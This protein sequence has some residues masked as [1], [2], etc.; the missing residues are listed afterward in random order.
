MGNVLAFCEFQGD[1]LRTSALANI[2]SAFI[3]FLGV[4]A[5]LNQVGVAT[6]VTTP[7]LIAQAGED[8]VVDAEAARAWLGTV[9]TPEKCF[10][11]LEDQ[12]HDDHFHILD[13]FLGITPP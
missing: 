4:I 2:A 10:H 3:L 12:F 9:G 1:S 7:V 13:S 11:L 8:R 6:T 5:A